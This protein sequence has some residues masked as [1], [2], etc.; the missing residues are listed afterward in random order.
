MFDYANKLLRSEYRTDAVSAARALLGQ[1]LVTELDGVRTSGIISETEAYMG[2]I[3]RASHAWGGRRTARTETMYAEGGISYVYLIYGMYYCMNVVVNDKE[4]PEAVL[5]RELIPLEG[6]DAM[7]RRRKASNRSVSLRHL[8]DGPGKL[9][10]ALGIDKALNAVPL[11]G[12]KMYICD[13]GYSLTG[14]ICASE[15]INIDYAGEDARKLWRFTIAVD[16]PLR[17]LTAAQ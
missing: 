17:S 10:R 6:V 14:E 11:D 9:C 8:T 12:D 13:L 7:L 16:D 15:R 1:V 3:D 2:K 5:I 4:I